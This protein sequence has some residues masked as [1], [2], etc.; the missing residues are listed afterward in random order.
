MGTKIVSPRAELA[1]LRGMTHKDKKIAGML[2]SSVDESYFQAD[3]S[4]EIYKAIKDNMSKSGEVPPFRLVVE[5][6]DLRK[7]TREYFRDSQATVTTT[8]EAV[9]AVKILNRYRQLRGL[10]EIALK[11]DSTLQADDRL[12]IDVLMDDVSAKM[13]SVRTSKQVTD[14]FTH[15]G[16]NNNSLELVDQLLNGD[17]SDDTIPTGIKPFD[18]QSGGLMRGSLTTLGATSGGGKSVMALQLAINQ[19]ELG[20]KVILVPLEMSRVEMTSRLMA[21]IVKLDVTRI[22]QKR[23]TQDERDM[24]ARKFKKWLRKVKR[25]GGRLTVFKPLEDVSIDDV[26]SATASFDADTVL[27]DYI[28]LLAGT[29]G[30]D[31]WKKLGAVARVAKINAESTNRANVLLCQVSEEGKIRYAGAISEHSSQS[32]V[33]VTRK[34]EREKQVGRIKVEQP[35]ARNSKSFPFEIGIHWEFMRVVSVA[36]VSGDVGDVTEPM[37]NLTT[38]L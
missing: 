3:E 20:Y 38:D 9:K 32:W 8:E 19:A 6:P 27:V 21:N 10:Y 35:K 14:A 15:F 28:S 31:N 16:K 17:A 26:F 7:T 36:D 12:E 23:L 30:D 13:A 4:K 24:A 33:W 22:L 2:L 11:I 25:A 34:E 18:E 5:D 29:D 1:V 37:K